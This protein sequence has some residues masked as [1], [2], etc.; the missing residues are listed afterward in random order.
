MGID[1][2]E[3]DLNLLAIEYDDAKARAMQRS[4]RSLLP[5][6]IACALS[7][8][9]IHEEIVR[10]GL[11]NTLIL[12]DD[13]VP[14]N[15]N[16]LPGILS[17]WPKDAGIVYLG[18]WRR[19]KWGF[20]QRAKTGIYLIYRWFRLGGWHRLKYERVRNYYCRPYSRHFLTSG[21]HNGSHAYSVSL[22]AAKALS[23]MQQPVIYL[24]D[25]LLA[26]A[27]T[28]DPRCKGYSCRP[29]LFEQLH[30]IDNNE[31]ITLR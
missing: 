4:P 6:E 12:E 2:H 29:L 27:A 5:G 20:K 1:K 24:A 13:V 16:A 11:K 26:F 21:Y 7:H 14:Q 30:R 28:G 17:D 23:Q 9:K 31:Y 8:R 10:R 25:H 22:E 19:E 18:Y 3:L 15:M